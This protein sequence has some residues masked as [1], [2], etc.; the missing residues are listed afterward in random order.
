MDSAMRNGTY[1]PDLWI[2]YTGKSIDDLWK[3]YSSKPEVQLAY[4]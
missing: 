1:S 2:K 3:E 4:K